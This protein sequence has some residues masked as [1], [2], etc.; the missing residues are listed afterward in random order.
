MDSLKKTHWYGKEVEG[1]LYGIDTLCV[2]LPFETFHKEAAKF[3]HILIGT[4]LIDIMYEQENSNVKWEDIQM[5]L[6]LGKTVSLEARPNQLDRIPHT[7]KLRC[8]ILLWI[9]VPE[10]S[11]LKQSD[12]VK[13]S[14]QDHDMYVYT[15]FNGQRVT[16][17][18]YYHD[19]Y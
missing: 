7:M 16:R 12:S 15:L 8:H 13:L 10:L 17:N 14:I 11:Q 6:D 9:N 4:S 2:A 5:L 18:D 1:R 19:R 3:T